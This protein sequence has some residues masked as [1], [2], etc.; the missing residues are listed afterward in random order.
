[1]DHDYDRDARLELAGWRVRRISWR[2]VFE[3]PGL[4]AQLVA[5]LLASADNGH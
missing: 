3:Q 1:M 4:V 5:H 2:Q